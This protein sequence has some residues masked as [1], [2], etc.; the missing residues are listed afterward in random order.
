M[1]ED[2]M[3][4][5]AFSNALFVGEIAIPTSRV[6]RLVSY[7]R[8]YSTVYDLATMRIDSQEDTSAYEVLTYH[9]EYCPSCG[10]DWSGRRTRFDPRITAYGCRQGHEW[11]VLG[12]V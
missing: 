11:H 3:P 2:V 10:G 5:R 12:G 6:P 8:T 4:W 7:S 1:A 9:D